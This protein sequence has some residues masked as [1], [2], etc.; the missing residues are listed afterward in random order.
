MKEAKLASKTKFLII[1]I[2]NM[3]LLNKTDNT[4]HIYSR[5]PSSR[6]QVSAKARG[7]GKVQQTVTIYPRYAFY[8]NVW[9]LSESG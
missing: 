4:T 7:S 6:P 8:K 2:Y 9:A 5:T 1:N 3:A